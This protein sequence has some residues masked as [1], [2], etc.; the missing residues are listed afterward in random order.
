MSESIEDKLNRETVLAW[1]AAHPDALQGE[2]DL[3]RRLQFRGGDGQRIIGLQDYR[4]QQLQ[5][6]KQR[7]ES[8]LSR[9]EQLVADNEQL[10]H[11]L[12][13]WVLRMLDALSL[14]ALLQ[15]ALLGLKEDFSAETVALHV[16][17][18]P[19]DFSVPENCWAQEICEPAVINLAQMAA[20]RLGRLPDSQKAAL[21]GPL[22]AQVQSAVILPMNTQGVLAVGS[23]DP[24]HY[25]AG[26]GT[27]MLSFASQ[28]LMRL[29]RV[30]G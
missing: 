6:D 14:E 17:C 15:Q 10:L 16:L 4:Q 19:D 22:A 20:P 7:L 18:L 11:K 8:E 12:H 23:S 13:Q 3:V 27:E 5:L 9:F 25:Q 1:L 28:C 29:L 26:M 2:D 24:L 30:H 21:F